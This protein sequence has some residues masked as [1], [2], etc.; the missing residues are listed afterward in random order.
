MGHNLQQLHKET[1]LLRSVDARVKVV[2]LLVLLVLELSCRTYLFPL[3]ITG[4][5]LFICLGLKVRPKLLLLRFAQPLFIA[6]LVILLKCFL[7]GTDPL[8]SWSVFGVDITGYRDGL[9]EGML[10][11]CRISGCVSLVAVLGFS[12]PFTDLMSA[13]AWL[14]VPRCVV[15]TAMFAWRYLFLLLDDAMVIYNAQKNRLG[16]V[17]YRRGLRSF[18]T[19]AG[20]MVIKAFD[21]SQTVTTAMAQRGYD[22]SLPMASHP[23]FKGGE[24]FASLALVGA[25]AALWQSC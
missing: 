18:G 19:L 9:R 24:V 13:L 10:I 17:G 1:G 25:L 4:L 20:A 14:R 11:A 12:T 8:F 21:N 15:E 3:F 6:L 23:P 5:S 7:T 22:G 16:Y 2:T